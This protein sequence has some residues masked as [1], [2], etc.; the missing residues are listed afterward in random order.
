LSPVDDRLEGFGPLLATV[1]ERIDGDE[2][3][4][5]SVGFAIAD[6]PSLDPCDVVH[7]ADIAMYR[8]KDR[9]QRRTPRRPRARL[10]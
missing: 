2:P 1:S 4:S 10:R 3:C 9:A 5:V 6:D 7:A 8:H